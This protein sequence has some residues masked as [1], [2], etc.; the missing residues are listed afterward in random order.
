MPAGFFELIAVLDGMDR[1]AARKKVVELLEAAGQVE[2][3]EPTVHAVPHAQRGDAIVEPWLTDQWYVNA[4]ELAKR[5][6]AVVESGETR[7]HSE[8]LGEDLLRVDAQH[9]ALVHLAPDLVGPS[10]S[11]VVWTADSKIVCSGTFDEAE[12]LAASCGVYYAQ[13]DRD[14]DT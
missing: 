12:A 5:A 9:R 14:R 10:N 7:V 8:E 1:F 2:K 13:A 3:I 6:I 4:A 11:G